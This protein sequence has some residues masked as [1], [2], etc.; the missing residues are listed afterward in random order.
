MARRATWCEPAP[1]RFPFGLPPNRVET[2]LGVSPVPCGDV[3]YPPRIDSS[4]S[5]GLPGSL[6]SELLQ[7]GVERR[8]DGTGGTTMSGRSRFPTS[9]TCCIVG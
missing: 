1:S 7:D 2:G 9:T 5:V 6:G 3:E 8:F 4:F